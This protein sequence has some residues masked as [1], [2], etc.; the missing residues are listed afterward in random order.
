MS[1]KL[2][3][4]LIGTGNFAMSTLIPIINN[5]KEG[6][7]SSLLG[8]EGLSLY[9]A[10]KRFNID[11]ITTNENDFYEDIDVVCISTP[12][13]THF[14]L[15][16]K[17]IE[18]S[19]PVWVEKPL[20]I[21]IKELKAIR[22]KMYSNK[23][24]Y[25]VGYN[26]SSAPWTNFM[27][28]KINSKKTNISMTINAGKLPADHWLLDEN[29]CGGRILGECCHFIDLALN[30]LS[31]TKLIRI[32]CVGRDRYYQDTGNYILAFEDGSKVDIHYRHDLPASI[33]KEKIVVKFLQKTYTNNNWK[34]FSGGKFFNLEKPK[35]GKGHNEAISNFFQKIK[36]NR[37]S[38]ENEINDIVFSTYVAIKLQKMSKGDFLDIFDC[39]KD[40]ILSNPSEY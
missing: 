25:A 33:P 7:L 13:Q 10:Q 17:A 39:Y 38:T 3:V 2:K 28:N 1:N 21:S 19:L 16:M 12:H 27:I 32:D 23:L 20:V 9:I 14:N 4:G 40:E 26:R 18:L 31:H 11:K 37:V 30:L 15:S 34:R 5:S 8:R 22:Q 36:N 6:Y 24:I 35:K 29:N